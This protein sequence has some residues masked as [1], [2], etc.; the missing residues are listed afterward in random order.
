MCGGGGGCC[1]GEVRGGEAGWKGG[2]GSVWGRG[3]V[4]WWCLWWG[5]WGGVGGVGGVGV[6]VGGGVVVVVGGGDGW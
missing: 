3:G 1:G 4:V 6:V 5:G 2:A